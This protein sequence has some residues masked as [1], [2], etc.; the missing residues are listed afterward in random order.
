MQKETDANGAMTRYTYDAFGRKPAC[1]G[2]T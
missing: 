2:P 1:V